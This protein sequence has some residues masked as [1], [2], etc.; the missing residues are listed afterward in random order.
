MAVDAP[1]SVYTC[2]TAGVDY[3]DVLQLEA[4]IGDLNVG[5]VSFVAPTAVKAY[6]KQKPEYGTDRAPVWVGNEANGYPAYGTSY[7]AT[8]RIYFGDF[9]RNAVAQ[10][11]EIDIIVDIFSD[12]AAGNIIVTATGLFD[13]GNRNPNAVVWADVSANV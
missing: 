9:S 4:S 2:N 6:F 10:F 1:G 7:A 13:S 12:A 3:A 8:N 11:G 5:S